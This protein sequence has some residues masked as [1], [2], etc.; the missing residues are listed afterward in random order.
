MKY[1]LLFSF[2]LSQAAYAFDV[3]SYPSTWDFNQDLEDK[4]IVSSK[5]S[6]K[7]ERFTF[8]EK[9]M[10]HLAITLQNYLQGSS[11]EDALRAFSNS[12]GRIV[13]YDIEDKTFAFA[14]YYPGDNEYGALYEVKAKGKG[15]FKLLAK[16][17]DGDIFC[18]MH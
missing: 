17:E 6:D 8:N 15:A 3:C 16:V 1:I 12:D 2:L 7:H 13:Y 10:I 18:Y 5:I 11:L 4:G 14:Q 9:K